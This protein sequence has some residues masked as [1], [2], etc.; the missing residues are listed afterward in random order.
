LI[1]LALS[2]VAAVGW[3]ASDYFGGDASRRDIPPLSVV[4][5]A[6]LL[7]VVMLL[8]A[9]I[10]RG[11]PA[12]LSPR[13]LLAALAGVAVT[14]EL[15]LIYRALS[16]GQAFITAPT[17]ALGAST[18]VGVGLVGGERL[19]G[20]LGLGL[21]CALVGGGISAWAPAP[22]VIR[23]GAGVRRS[24]GACLA[25]AL[26]VGTMLSSL[27]AAARVDPYWATATEHASTCL[28]AALGAWLVGRRSGRDM[29]PGRAQLPML[30]LVAAVGVAGDLAYVGA[31]QHGALS[32][33][34]AIGSLY[35]VTTIALGR[36][37][38]GDRATKIQLG[39]IAL[40]LT[41]AAVIGA[42]SG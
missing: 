39:G 26:S 30:A 15:S 41:G 12:A 24:V 10:A 19:G 23:D 13:L 22:A 38:R 5:A 6:E 9:L 42:A 31:S 33:V 28:S 35:P 7:G 11:A 37:L 16:R 20:A 36:V 29:R 1:P 8:P 17:G 3:G 4:A 40:A 2:L 14:V 21:A 32:I 18:A 34:S 27:H 25:A